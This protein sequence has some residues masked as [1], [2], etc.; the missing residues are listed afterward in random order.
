MPGSLGVWLGERK[1]GT[2]TNLPGDYNLFAFDADYL[3]DDHPPVLSQSFIGPSG[4]T[5]RIVPRTHRIS[6]PFFANLLPEEDSLL[7]AIVARQQKIN[8]TRD[9]AFF[10]VLGLDLPGAVIMRDPEIEELD[11][12]EDAA[13]ESD[14]RREH[15]LRFSLAGMQPKFSASMIGNRLTLPVRGIG[16]D[17]IAKL[18]TNAWR[19]LPENEYAVMS[20]ARVI[21]LDVPRVELVEL[22]SIAGLPSEIPALRTE[23]PRIV[24]AI[25]RFDRLA[26]GER[27]HVEDFNQIAG[28]PPAEK[29]DHKSTHWIANV[30]ATLCPTEDVDEF[31]RRLVFGVCVGNNDMHLKNWAVT[32]PDGRN[33]RLAPMYDF[34][35]TR[36]YFP[37]APLTLPIGGERSFDRIDRAALRAFAERAEISAKRTLIVARE[38]VAA[39][40]DAWPHIK[41]TIADTALCD[42]LE[43]QFG[44]VPLMSGR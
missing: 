10:P 42:T 9:F 34:V 40:R 24:Y 5:V 3:D 15:A 43:R 44:V 7:R 31:V 17:W 29:Y 32:Y 16:G 19:R 39:L 22:D 37:T 8:R 12:D 41:E 25:A 33:A 6:P 2:I 23:E 14:A 11:E 1:I 30:I 28:Q 38:T 18:P 27:V 13:L 26:G 20:L 36:A 21:G 4:A 35:C